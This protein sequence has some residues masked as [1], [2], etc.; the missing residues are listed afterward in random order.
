MTPSANWPILRYC[1]C[2]DN[3]LC[4]TCVPGY[5]H[6]TPATK[7]GKMFTVAYCTIGIPLAMI[8]FQVRLDLAGQLEC[9]DPFW[10]RQV[11]VIS[12][13]QVEDDYIAWWVSHR[14]PVTLGA[15]LNKKPFFTIDSLSIKKLSTGPLKIW[16]K[17]VVQ[18]SCIS[19]KY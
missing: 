4:Y 19:H 13:R 1:M 17:V 12:G 14:L 8:M 10:V 3:W 6:S 5:G 9:K 2:H 7:P 11:F 16:E 18:I 15:I